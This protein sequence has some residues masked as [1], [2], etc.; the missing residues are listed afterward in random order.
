MVMAK[1]LDLRS[2]STAAFSA[3]RVP[4]EGPSLG[5]PLDEGGVSTG[6]ANLGTPNGDM[7]P[8]T[9]DDLL[10]GSSSSEFLDFK[11]VVVPPSSESE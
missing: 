6:F 4:T 8:W 5:C 11:C 7:G 1:A 2:T 10:A 9:R 3:S